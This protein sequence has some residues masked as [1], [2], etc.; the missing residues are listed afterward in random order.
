MDAE[1]DPTL[2]VQHLAPAMVFPDDDKQVSKL[3]ERVTACL[4]D[5]GKILDLTGIPFWEDAC[6]AAYASGIG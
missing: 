1:P 4:T 2:V 6:V 3:T 5:G